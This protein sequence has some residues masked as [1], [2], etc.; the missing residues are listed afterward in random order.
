MVFEFFLTYMKIIHKNKKAIFD[1]EILDKYLA[2]LILT[3]PEVK[4]IRTGH[5][6]L[7]GSYISINKGELV[8]KNAH[9]SRYAYDQS[10]NYDPFRERKLLLNKKEINKI[11]TQ[12]NTQGITVIPL[13][14]GLMGRHI[15]LEIAIAK[16]KKKHDKRQ[17]MKERDENR[18]LNRMIKHYR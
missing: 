18:R 16:G 5:V 6:N 4:S 10:E 15:K 12:L 11:E 3:G 1:Y 2:G 17:T 14:I 7:K 9:I 8:L 13:V